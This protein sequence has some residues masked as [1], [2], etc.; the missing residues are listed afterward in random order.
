MIAKYVLSEEYGV[1]L[2]T[3][4]TSL[5]IQEIADEM[6]V[7]VKH[8]FHL[9]V[10]MLKNRT[11]SFMLC[12]RPFQGRNRQSLPLLLFV[13]LSLALCYTSVYLFL[14][15]CLFNVLFVLLGVCLYLGSFW[16]YFV[17]TIKI[18][19]FSWTSFYRFV[20]MF[21]ICYL[22]LTVCSLLCI[23]CLC[24]IYTPLLFRKQFAAHVLIIYRNASNKTEM[25]TGGRRLNVTIACGEMFWY[26]HRRKHVKHVAGCSQADQCSGCRCHLLSLDSRCSYSHS[27][28]ASILNL[29]ARKI[30]ILLS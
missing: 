19:L 26:T 13:V 10:E 4:D 18:V 3:K 27:V 22:C 16:N 20:S 11:I 15:A 5:R 30:G 24:L 23:S 17:N 7:T 9:Y 6:T 12:S 29:Q 1:P 14:L 28:F 25:P 8:F 21:M 2:N